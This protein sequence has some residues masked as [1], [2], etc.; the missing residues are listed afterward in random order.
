MGY[1]GF[2]LFRKWTIVQYCCNV[3]RYRLP[4]KPV[5]YNS[6]WKLFDGRIETLWVLKSYF[7]RLCSCESFLRLERETAEDITINGVHIPKGVV[8]GIPIWAL[9][10][11]PEHWDNPEEFRP[12]R[13]NTIVYMCYNQ[14]AANVPS[15]D[16]LILIPM[17]FCFCYIWSVLNFHKFDFICH[18][19]DF[20]ITKGVPYHV[21]FFKMEQCFNYEDVKPTYRL[22][23]NDSSFKI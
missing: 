22:R 17:P 9:H 19:V 2:T 13:Y 1:L 18:F 7:A 11:D 8:V 10:S 4:P 3:I 6:D 12:E 14:A 5:F 20:T 15:F 16:L 21:L 23:F